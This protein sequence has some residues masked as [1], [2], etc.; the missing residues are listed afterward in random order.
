MQ[1]LYTASA[2]V[3]TYGYLSQSCLMPVDNLCGG[4]A[5]VNIQL[6]VDILGVVF[7]RMLGDIK[8]FCD[9]AVAVAAAD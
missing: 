1:S 2:I 7:D 4:M 9:I 5:A 6:A 3:M 8:R